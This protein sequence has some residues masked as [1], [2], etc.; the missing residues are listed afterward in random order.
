M[1]RF[2]DGFDHYGTNTAN[3]L[4]GVYADGFNGS[5]LISAPAFGARTGP[6]ALNPGQGGAPRKV[7]DWGTATAFL[8]GCGVA[9]DALPANNTNVRITEMRDGSNATAF[10]VGI[11]ST[12]GVTLR[13]SSGTIVAQTQ[14]PVIVA[15]NWHF[16]EMEIDTV[17]GTFRLDVDGTTVINSTGLTLSSTA[18]AGVTVGAVTT[19]SLTSIWLDDLTIRDTTGDRNNSFDGD[20]RVATL[21]PAADGDNQ[22]WTPQYRHKLGTGILDLHSTANACISSPSST[23]TNLPAGDFTLEG[24]FR[25]DTLP[26]GGRKAVLFNKWDETNNRRSYQLFLG[27]PTL[28]NGNIVFRTSTDGAAGTVVN[29][30]SFPWPGGAPALYTWY[31]VA[32]VRSSDQLLLF[33]N[34]TQYGLPQADSST[35]FVGT[36]PLAIGGQVEGTNTVTSN[37]TLDGWVDEVRMSVGVARYTSNFT[38]TTVPFGRNSSTD[39]DFSS[40]VLLCGFDSGI[41]DESSYARTVTAR[42][43]AVAVTPDDGTAAFQAI[44][45]HTPQDDTFVQAALTP[46]TQ[47]LTLAANPSDGNSVTVGT[48]TDSGSNAAVYTFKTALASAFDV[49]IGATT[50]DTLTNLIAALN[51]SAGAGTIYGTGTLVNDDVVA[52]GLPSPQMLVTASTAGIVGNAIASTSSGLTGGGGWGAATLQGGTDIPSNSEFFFDRPPVGTTLVRA[53]QIVNRSFKSDAGP[54]SVQ[55]SFVGPLGGVTAGADNALTVS[56]VYRWDVYETDPDT[57]SSITPSTIVG[58]RVRLD[59][60]A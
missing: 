20:L 23:T 24:F 57:D 12:G 1:M 4:D 31:H 29:N 50:A 48:Y 15:S 36:E 59:R 51:L 25:F 28:N 19:G 58:G 39:P 6:F 60:T 55:S 41:A 47:T 49:L 16:V 53:V 13:N 35:Y 42:N 17:A 11:T 38:P 30:I 2:M 3:M 56:P 45:H 21:F 5:T 54:A 37:T 46:A 34:G 10:S 27:G 9:V 14:A 52:S 40:V 18:I 26:T 8:I 43:S 32:V 22:G 7:F 44:Y 33:I